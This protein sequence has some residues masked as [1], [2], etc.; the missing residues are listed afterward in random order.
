[1]ALFRTELTTVPTTTM[2]TVRLPHA[3]TY[4]TIELV[5]CPVVPSGKPTDQKVGGSN[6]FGRAAGQGSLPPSSK[7]PDYTP[8]M[9]S[10]AWVRMWRLT[11]C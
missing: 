9:W 1:V 11:F 4:T 7:S 10:R 2:T 5:S 8:T 6:P 3:F